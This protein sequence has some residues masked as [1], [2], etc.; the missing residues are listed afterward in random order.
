MVFSEGIFEGYNEDE[1]VV[2]GYQ[3]VFSNAIIH[4]VC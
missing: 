3:M 4:L 2:D 1:G